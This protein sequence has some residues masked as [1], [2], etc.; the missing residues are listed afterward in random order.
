MYKYHPH[1]VALW[2]AG[3]RT[4][5]GLWSYFMLAALSRLT[6]LCVLSL[7]LL[8]GHV[9]LSCLFTFLDSVPGPIFCLSSLIVLIVLIVQ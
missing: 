4:A 7:M 9:G 5:V 8:S 2:T 1:L 6:S 3:Q